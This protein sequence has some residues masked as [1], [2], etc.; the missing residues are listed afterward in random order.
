MENW[1]KIYNAQMKRSF[2]FGEYEILFSKKEAKESFNPPQEGKTPLELHKESVKV[3]K[4]GQKVKLR[5]IFKLRL[6]D[7]MKEDS[8]EKAEQVL[9]ELPQ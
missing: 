5:K 2:K 6:I 3:L 9:K 7:A 4:N 8:L 1:Y